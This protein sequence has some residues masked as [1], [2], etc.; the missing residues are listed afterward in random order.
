MGE[1][2]RLIVGV[3]HPN[4]IKVSQVSFRH[5]VPLP[6]L[7]DYCSQILHFYLTLKSG[8]LKPAKLGPPT[9]QSPPS[10][11]P[12]STGLPGASRFLCKTGRGPEKRERALEKSQGGPLSGSGGS[13]I[14]FQH[15]LTAFKVAAK[16]LDD[17]QDP[18]EITPSPRRPPNS[19]NSSP[20]TW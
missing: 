19:P 17:E 10:G 5:F 9:A 16:G 1:S 12:P 4:S 8:T 13:Y 2:E 3:K 15:W 6:T 18:S 20:T 14:S 7:I 11:S